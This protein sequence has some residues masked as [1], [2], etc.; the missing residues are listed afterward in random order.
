MRC[1]WRIGNDLVKEYKIRRFKSKLIIKMWLLISNLYNLIDIFYYDSIYSL[2][3]IFNY[4]PIN[5]KNWMKNSMKIIFKNRKSSNFNWKH[6][7]IPKKSRFSVDSRYDIEYPTIWR[8]F[9]EY[10]IYFGLYIYFDSKSR[11]YYIFVT[12]FSF[13]SYL[14]NF[15]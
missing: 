13:S 4:I 8:Y 3:N 6:T 12:F 5:I 2:I 7:L 9:T 14:S 15:V 11:F 1:I 10:R